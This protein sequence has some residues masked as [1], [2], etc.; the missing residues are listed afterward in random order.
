M[1]GPGRPGRVVALV[2]VAVVVLV[3]LFLWVFP[4]VERTLT[5][6]TVGMIG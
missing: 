4:W 5:D 2:V 3:A 6:P 1:T